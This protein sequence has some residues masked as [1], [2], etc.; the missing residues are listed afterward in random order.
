M[1]HLL[2]Y[3]S[4]RQNGGRGHNF[5]RWGAQTFI[6]EL[7]LPG[8]DLYDTLNAYPALTKGTGTVTFELHQV[9]DETANYINGVEERCGYV[10]EDIQVGDVTA[11]LFYM[12]KIPKHFVKVPSGNWDKSWELQK[13]EWNI[14]I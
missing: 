3:G 7:T 9:E 4:L 8:Y 14:L 6:K 11:T 10:R 2:V 13:R 1:K 12:N 5:N